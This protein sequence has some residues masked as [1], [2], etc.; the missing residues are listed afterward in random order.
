MKPL[1]LGILGF[2]EGNGHPYSWAAI[3]NGYEP[4]T[5][6][7]CSFP[8][9]PRYLSARSFPQDAVPGAHVA[10]VWTQDRSLSE[11]IAKASRIENVVDDYLDMV[12]KVDAILLARDDADTH[13][14]LAS[15][16][17]EAGIPVYIDKPIA[18]SIA[19]LE[20][21][22][23]IERYPGQIFTCSALGYAQELRLD[24]ATRQ[25]L[26]RIKYIDACV[27]SSWEKYGIHIIEPVLNLLAPD[28]HP[29]NLTVSHAEDKTSLTIT[30]E[31][32]IQ[33]TLTALGKAS[34]P[35]S[36]R[37]FG[38]N[39]CHEMVF[40]DAF[41]AFKTALQTFIDSIINRNNPVPQSRTRKIVSI[42][43][44]GLCA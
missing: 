41:S 19:Q 4:E 31:S 25:R 38:E 39:G 15:P 44:R 32:N 12:G 43:E 34:A 14:E 21:L 37:V 36:I 16:F 6:S 18:T 13:F 33:S 17:I 9:I 20:E 11:H 24:D 29:R 23:A 10:Y 22:Y 42:I 26:G 8:A 5:M 35:I 30:W 7:Q 1:V 27:V 28:D 40:R 2:S 3:F